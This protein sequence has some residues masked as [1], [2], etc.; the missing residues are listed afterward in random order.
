[1]PNQPF[2]DA[3]Y[4]VPQV[5]SRYYKMKQGDNQFRILSSPILG[6]EFWNLDGK[7]VRRKTGEAIDMTELRPNKDGSAGTVK[8]FWALPVWDYSSNE[9]KVAEFTQKSILQAIRDLVKDE[10]WADPKTYDLVI[11]RSGEGFET[12][13]SVKPKLPK[14]LSPLITKAWKAV[15][16]AGFNLEALYAGTDPFTAGPAKRGIVQ[17]AKDETDG[18]AEPLPELD[19]NFEDIEF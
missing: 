15:Q 8:H 6:N 17:L 10:D 7:P 1:M 9:V 5:A 13:Y 18:T 2:L 19:E 4:E 16:D 11:T 14:E 12:E 3:S